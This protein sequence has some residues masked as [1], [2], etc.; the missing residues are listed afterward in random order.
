VNQFQSARGLR[1]HRVEAGDEDL[2]KK[3]AINAGRLTERE[4]EYEERSRRS[5]FSP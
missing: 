2:R 3:S 4:M 1:N 5:V